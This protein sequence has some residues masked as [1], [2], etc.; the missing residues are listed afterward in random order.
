MTR[1]CYRHDSEWLLN[2]LKKPLA[3]ITLADLRSFAHALSDAGPAPISLA[4][5]LA[6]IKLRSEVFQEEDC[7]RPSPNGDRPE[8]NDVVRERAWALRRNTDISAYH[9]HLCKA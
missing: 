6:A 9:F 8:I 3:R 4:R 7:N 2:Y 5:T 1:G